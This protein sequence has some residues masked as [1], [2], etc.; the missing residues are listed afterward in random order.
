MTEWIDAKKQ[1]PQEDVAVLITCRYV[2][3]GEPQPWVVKEA[4]SKDSFYDENHH[5][6]WLANNSCDCCYNEFT[7]EVS[8]WMPMPE[9]A[10][11]AI[12]DATFD[13]SVNTN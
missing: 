7:G 1:L 3:K 10:D 4:V 9:K 8:H 6:W 2:F 12:G 11:E 5:D 13:V